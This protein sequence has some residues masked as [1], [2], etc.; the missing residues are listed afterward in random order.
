[1]KI[2]IKGF[3]SI[4]E[5]R[6]F[7]FLPL[8]MLTGINSSGKTSL[9]QSL[10]LLKQTLESE[11]KEVLRLDGKFISTENEYD[12][13][14][15]KSETDQFG[16]IIELGADDLKFLKGYE[17]A[18]ISWL[19][20]A[21]VFHINSGIYVRNIELDVNHRGHHVGFTI[22]HSKDD[23]SGQGYMITP[24]HMKIRRGNEEISFDHPFLISFSNFF[25]LFAIRFDGE[26]DN[27]LTLRL[28]LI[29]DIKS[30]LTSF[31]SNVFYVG[32]LRV[33]PEPVISYSNSSFKDVGIDGLYTRFVLHNLRDEKVND[34][35]TLLEATRR[36]I[37]NEFNMADSLEIIKDGTNS[38]RVVLKN[39]GLEVDLCHMGLGVSQV[40]PIIVQG[41]LVPEGGMLIIDSPEV[42]MHPSIQAGLVDFFIE[43]SH[44]GRKVLIETHSDHMITRLRRRV[45]EGLDPKIVNLCFVTC[46][47]SGSTYET[48]SIDEQGVFYGG[49]PEGFMDTQDIDFR[50]IVEAKFALHE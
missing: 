5:T 17:T 31:F 15:G 46:T 28:P 27:P 16:F 50:K 4:H 37:C 30:L 18:N 19:K 32:P 21:V 1:M 9:I 34:R 11:T 38:Y 14:N 29:D 24:R 44:R 49:L 35:E 13:V 40:L 22:D 48:L 43:L 10:L 7:S 26:D 33:K 25:P 12:L 23:R 2:S 36:W 6:E 3:K 20:Y 41:L 39:N 47:K 42:H 45:A 8:T